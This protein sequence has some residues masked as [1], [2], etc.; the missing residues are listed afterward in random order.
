MYGVI[1][2]ESHTSLMISNKP[3]PHTIVPLGINQVC[4]SVR[5]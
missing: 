2:T 5:P 3:V 1:C 4:D